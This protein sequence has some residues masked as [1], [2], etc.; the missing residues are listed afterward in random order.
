MRKGGFDM[1]HYTKYRPDYAKK[2]PGLE[3]DK[4]VMDVLKETDRKTEYIERD[5]KGVRYRSDGKG[6]SVLRTRE[7]SLE[8]LTGKDMSALTAA[9]AEDEA[10]APEISDYAEL[11][12]CIGKLNEDDRHLIA[13]LYYKGMTQEQ[14]AE[15]TGKSQTK[16]SRELK[17]ILDEIKNIWEIQ[18]KSE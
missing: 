13:A 3:I 14:Y 8:E 6:K 16:V 11:R 15:K 17:R 7:V 4:A 12:R 2:Y 5:I 1:A 9:S 18:R 10:L